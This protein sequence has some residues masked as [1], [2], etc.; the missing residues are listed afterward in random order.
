MQPLAGKNQQLFQLKVLN[1]FLNHLIEYFINSSKFYSNLKTDILEV[2]QEK[3]IAITV[4]VLL[5]LFPHTYSNCSILV[6][7]SRDLISLQTMTSSRAETIFFFYL[8]S[9]AEWLVHF[10]MLSKYQLNKYTLSCQLS[11]KQASKI[12]QGLI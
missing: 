7:L 2:Q 3:R 1:Y 4:L 12:T 5:M 11:E 8:W 10:E 9:I 6:S